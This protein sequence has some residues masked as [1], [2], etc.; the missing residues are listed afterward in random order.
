M[1]VGGDKGI[2]DS[3]TSRYCGQEAEHA[4][5][6]RCREH[7]GGDGVLR[8]T[9]RLMLIAC[10]GWLLS[11]SLPTPPACSCAHRC[12][13]DGG[14]REEVPL[15]QEVA[16][17][18]EEVVAAAQEGRVAAAQE[19]RVAAAPHRQACGCNLRAVGRLPTLRHAHARQL[20]PGACGC[21]AGAGD[22]PGPQ[23]APGTP[24]ARPLTCTP[25][26]D[27]RLLSCRSPVSLKPFRHSPCRGLRSHCLHQWVSPSRLVICPPPPQ[28]LCRCV[29]SYCGALTLSCLASA[30]YV[31]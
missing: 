17:A 12:H 21:S 25:L 16:A 9:P 15:T 29:P 28:R 22:V 8:P 2:G 10:P 13:R 27:R 3:L 7:L 19:G 5:Q 20:P 31:G 14:S 23:Q 1:K 24:F 18:P 26:P 11:H 4:C 6:H 30:S